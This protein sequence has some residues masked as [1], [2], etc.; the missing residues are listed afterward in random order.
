M[1]LNF[2]NKLLVGLFL[3]GNS[4]FSQINPDGVKYWLGSGTDS[5]YV[6][7]NF[8]NQYNN[9]NRIW[10]YL[11]D[12]TSSVKD[13]LNVLSNDP[14]IGLTLSSDAIDYI[15]LGYTIGQSNDTAFWR[16]SK[17]D[18]SLNTWSNNLSFT[19][20]I[21]N[22]GVLGLSFDADDQDGN[23][24][25]N[26][27]G[28]VLYQESPSY[29]DEEVS[30]VDSFYGKGKFETVVVF[31]F[32]HEGV[33]SSIAYGVRFNY[34]DRLIDALNLIVSQDPKF[35]FVGEQYISTI[36][37]DTILKETPIDYAQYWSVYSNDLSDNEGSYI[38]SGNF[39]TLEEGH[40]YSYSYGKGSTAR[41][42][43]LIENE[44]EI[45]TQEFDVDEIKYWLGTG[46][47]SSYVVLN[48]NNQYNNTNRVWG[49]LSDGT[50]T[51]EEIIKDLSD[52][53]AISVTIDGGLIST[54][55]MGYTSGNKTDT[56]EWRL[57]CSNLAFTQGLFG[58]SIDNQI[59]RNEV[60]V[61]SFDDDINNDVSKDFPVGSY[62]FQESPDYLDSDIYGVKYFVGE[63]ELTTT[64]VF[65][66]NHE[67]YEKSI[68]FGVRFNEGDSLLV[69]LNT[70]QENYDLFSFDGDVY[71]S[72]V[73]Y[74]TISK[75][76]PLD[77]SM[78]WSVYSNDLSDNVGSIT[79][80]G[81]STKMEPRH[82]YSYVHGIGA[83]PRRFRR[84]FANIAGT[85]GSNAISKDSS[86]I[87]SWASDVVV[88]RGFI[89]A[90]NELAEDQGSVRA[91]YGEESNAI[92]VASGSSS[93]V[94]S[95]GDAG[96]AILTFETPITNGQGPDFVVFENSFNDSNLELAFV[97]V[98]SNGVDF[99][100]FPAISLTQTRNQIGGFG[101]VDVLDLYN[102]AGSFKQG[103]GTPFDL[104]EL[105][106]TE[107][108]DLSNITHVKLVDVVGS[109]DPAFGTYDSEGNIINGPFSTPYWSSGFD[110]DG[111]G[112]INENTAAALNV[113][114]SEEQ[115]LVYPNPASETVTFTAEDEIKIYS[116]SGQLM[117]ILDTNSSPTYSVSELGLET[118]V[119]IVKSGGLAQKLMIK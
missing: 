76:T 83:T 19:D 55:S 53:P 112:V 89:D 4:L 27:L 67:G 88:S 52:D 96:E 37:Y 68:A 8:N 107:D 82:Y 81:N 59:G 43:T 18:V 10:G 109:I 79:N 6:I 116:I 94:V 115:M 95:L 103:Y 9:T 21:A 50:V 111:V 69:A 71:I 15:S 98:S 101:S 38:N 44:L 74:D 51:I 36:G 104:E 49:Y 29:M 65:D 61:I 106:G 35:S 28:D 86:I 118:G 3:L 25:L 31:D 75:T 84:M 16:L 85:N 47:D 46:S 87:I 113:F 78:Y 114:I 100:R 70:I 7:L 17:S 39:T 33:D 20:V 102:L 90:S 63:G 93:D 12:G 45:L 54:A 32:N 1:K 57:S 24:Y 108:L 48:F 64:I 117:M 119:Y 34:G 62:L 80:A 26:P 30:E 72:T 66:F 77:Y 99:V 58:L 5:S 105:V 110:L 14:N 2:T 92:G 91:S 42:F 73:S 41:K 11:S 13:V 23:D 56:S 22:K 97:E 40:Y 60:L